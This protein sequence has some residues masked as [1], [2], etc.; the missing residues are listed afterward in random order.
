MQSC[1]DCRKVD[2]STV[3]MVAHLSGGCFGL[4]GLCTFLL[5]P[6][7]GADS[8]HVFKRLSGVVTNRTGLRKS[9]LSINQGQ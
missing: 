2:Q 1:Q 5:L 6:R 7:L 3:A 8:L 9:M 4:L